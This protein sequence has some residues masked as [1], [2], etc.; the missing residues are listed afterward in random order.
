MR[1]V[2]SHL[3]YANVI[4][5]LCLFL[6]LTGGTAVALRGKNSVQSNDIGPGAQVKKADVVNDSLTGADI[7]NKSGVDTCVNTVRL[8]NLCFRAENNIRVWNQAAQHCANLGLRLPT[9]GEARALATTYNLPNVDQ[10]ESFWT[11]EYYETSTDSWALVVKDDNS[12]GHTSAVNGTFET[13]C[14]TTPTN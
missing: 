10:T 1:R 4:S 7:K 9:L 11:D 13:A 5:T 6:L 8:G 12:V 2:R 3:T 14:V